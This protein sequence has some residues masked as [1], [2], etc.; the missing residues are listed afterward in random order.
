MKPYPSRN[1]DES[2]RIF[3][4]RLSRARRIVE[5]VF[6][7]LTCRF[8]VLKHAIPLEPEKV[9]NAVLACCALHNFLRTKKTTNPDYMGPGM[10]DEEDTQT[11]TV[12]HG[13]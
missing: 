4:Y 11:G 8:G 13:F 2:K 5:N 10:V 3:N 7:I 6:G 9:E 12:S 1:L